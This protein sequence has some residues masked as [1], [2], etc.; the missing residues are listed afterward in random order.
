[1]A[2]CVL[3]IAGSDPSGG[4][5]IQNDLKTIAAHGMHGASCI[6]VVTI[7]NSKGI[8]RPSIFLDPES[9]TMIARGDPHRLLAESQDPKVRSFLT[10]GKEGTDDK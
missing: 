7:Q 1:M 6:T 10:R 5:G 3:T 2:M 4:A 9:R 8:V